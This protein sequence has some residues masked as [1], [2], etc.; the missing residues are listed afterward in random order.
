MISYVEYPY[1]GDDPARNNPAGRLT[2]IDHDQPTD[3]TVG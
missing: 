2:D 3:S 1:V